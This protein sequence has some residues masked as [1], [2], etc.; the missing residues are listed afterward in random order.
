M[1]VPVADGKALAFWAEWVSHPTLFEGD[2]RRMEH[3][4]VREGFDLAAIMPAG[5]EN[6]ELVW[7][8]LSSVATEFG[9]RVS[10]LVVPTAERLAPIFADIN[11]GIAILTAT[12]HKLHERTGD[13]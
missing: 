5:P 3:A 13:L 4:A 2:L 10:A 1:T 11:S 12:P 8:T 9:D 7:K 6:R